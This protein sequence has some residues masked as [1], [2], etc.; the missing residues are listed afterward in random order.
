MNTYL[1]TI[2]KALEEAEKG[3]EENPWEYTEICSGEHPPLF[4]I[5]NELESS[6]MITVHRNHQMNITYAEIRH[7]GQEV[8][9]IIRNQETRVIILTKMKFQ[10][11]YPSVSYVRGLALSV[12][13]NL[14]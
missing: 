2:T 11:K 4:Q 6:D 8:L 14:H 3:S 9:K 7:Y 10:N 12:L 13:E 1:N 5:M